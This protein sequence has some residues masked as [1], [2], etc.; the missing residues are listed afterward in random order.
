LAIPSQPY[1]LM[2]QTGDAKNF[3]SWQAS[4]GATSYQI[5]RSLDGVNYSNLGTSTLPKYLDTA[6]TIGTQ[7]WYQVASVNGSGTST[8]ASPDASS[9]PSLIPA[10][11]S[12]MSLLSLRFAAQQKADR[13]GSNFITLADWNTQIT[14]A[15]YE[16]YDLLIDSD[17]DLFLAPRARFN[18]S[19]NTTTGVYPLPDGFI[20]FQDVNNA[21]FIPAPLYKL[22]GVDLGIN[23]ATNAWVTVKKYNFIDRNNFLYPNTNSTIYGVFNM[24]Y[25]PMGTNIELIPVPSSNQVVQL[26][27]IPKLP[28][29]IQDTDLTTLGYSGWLQYVITRAA[30]YA[31]DKEESSTAHLDAELVFLKKRIEDTAASRDQGRPDTIS[32]VRRATNFG[33]Y[34]P[35]DG[36]KGGW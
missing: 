33:A 6:V 11:R 22:Q 35:Y 21:D 17:P 8:Y 14:L 13:V 10:P 30:K 15:M 27:Y 34:G 25:R 28:E 16:L 4:A 24:E 7:Y 32:D 26:I 2:L 20:T 29:L 1:Q 5:Q 31:L 36:F 19:S 23:T 12:E 18:T 3:L 9:I